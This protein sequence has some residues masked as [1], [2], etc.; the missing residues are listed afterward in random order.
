MST[1]SPNCIV[2]ALSQKMEPF[3]KTPPFLPRVTTASFHRT[4]SFSWHTDSPKAPSTCVL[5]KA[6]PC[7][8]QPVPSQLAKAYINKCQQLVFGAFSGTLKSGFWWACSQ[9][10]H[11]LVPRVL[12]GLFLRFSGACSWAYQGLV[13]RDL[14]GHFPGFQENF[15]LE[16]REREEVSSL[17]SSYKTKNPLRV[18]TSPSCPL[19]RVSSQYHLH[20][21]DVEV[22]YPY[23]LL[24]NGRL[25]KPGSVSGR[26]KNCLDSLKSS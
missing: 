23:G 15:L 17:V 3:F 11:G 6:A 10:S 1:V 20:S 16:G 12:M 14:M 25:W 21:E 2:H 7:F 4:G 13:P 9:G 5:V 24:V 26:G 22:S 8:S 19:L 18:W